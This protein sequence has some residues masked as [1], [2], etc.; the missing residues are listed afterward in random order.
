MLKRG[1]FISGIPVSIIVFL[2]L[3]GC[4]VTKNEKGTEEIGSASGSDY[5]QSKLVAVDSCEPVLLNQIKG[6]WNMTEHVMGI[7]ED[8]YWDT[9]RIN[10]EDRIIFHSNAKFQAG[11][12]ELYGDYELRNNG[13][14]LYLKSAANRESFFRICIRKD[15][16]ELIQE[17]YGVDTVTDYMKLEREK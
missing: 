16:M 17:E 6:T 2:V 5:F 9:T 15:T 12:L 3:L 13:K 8:K 14:T 7:W 11:L 1:R 4:A 10:L